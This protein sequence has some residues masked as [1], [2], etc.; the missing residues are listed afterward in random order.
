MVQDGPAAGDV[1]T[2]AREMILMGGESN[3]C[4]LIR[5]PLL[6]LMPACAGQLLCGV[7]HNTYALFH[8]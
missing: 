3:I 2:I 6:R 1:D 7:F 5:Y 4:R 8:L